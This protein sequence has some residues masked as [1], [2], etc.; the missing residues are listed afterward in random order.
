MSSPLLRW[1]LRLGLTKVTEE[2]AAEEK[3]VKD[4]EGEEKACHETVVKDD[5]IPPPMTAEPSEAV[6]KCKE[7]EKTTP[8]ATAELSELRL[9]AK[10]KRRSPCL[11]RNRR[12]SFRNR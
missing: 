3:E 2:K 1:R 8:P 5:S 6:V 7:E 10:K 4:V 12:P 11:H 9:S